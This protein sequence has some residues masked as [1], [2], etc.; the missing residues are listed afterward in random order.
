MD[1]PA[2]AGMSA[3]SHR[4]SVTPSSMPLFWCMS[5][6]IDATGPP[7]PGPIPT[8]ALFDTRSPQASGPL[9]RLMLG[10]PHD[11]G[12]LRAV[13][14]INYVVCHKNNLS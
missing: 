14:K 1:M 6:D 5:F 4:L 11:D 12:T 13:S 10:I 7:L 9:A 8:P 3:F 2:D